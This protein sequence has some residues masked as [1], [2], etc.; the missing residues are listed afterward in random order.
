MTKENIGQNRL[1][2]LDKESPASSP[3]NKK[4]LDFDFE[5]K[6]HE[7]EAKKLENARKKEDQAEK[8]KVLYWTQKVVICYLS[9]VAILLFLIAIK[10]PK[11]K[12]WLSI[13]LEPEVIM[14]RLATTTATI[15]GMM[16]LIIASLFPK[17]QTEKES[18]TTKITI[19]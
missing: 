18:Q 10:I 4:S 6:V 15:V 11:W 12:G 2:W 17:N 19:N 16:A 5:T 7:N 1:G 8:I 13:D 9:Y 14:T 3:K